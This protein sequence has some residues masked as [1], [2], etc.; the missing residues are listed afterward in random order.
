MTDP[1]LGDLIVCYWKPPTTD[2]NGKRKYPWFQGGWYPVPPERRDE[3]RVVK[4]PG[5]KKKGGS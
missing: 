4:K 5:P 2:E 3:F 1:E